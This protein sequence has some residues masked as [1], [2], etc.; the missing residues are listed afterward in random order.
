M[1]GWYYAGYYVES[2]TGQRY[3]KDQ[4]ES[5]RVATVD[6]CFDLVGSRQ[7]G[8]AGNEIICWSTDHPYPL[9]AHGDDLRWNSNPNFCRLAN[10][11][12]K[13]RDKGQQEKFKNSYSSAISASTELQH[14][15]FCHVCN[16]SLRIISVKIK[17]SLVESQ[18]NFWLFLSFVQFQ[19]RLLYFDWSLLR[20]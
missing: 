14:A 3:D 2:L 9:N 19:H 1:Q 10:V 7:H 8:V 16:R 13:T 11:T 4:T 5:Q 15:L 12:C 17:P 18:A 6:S 20:M